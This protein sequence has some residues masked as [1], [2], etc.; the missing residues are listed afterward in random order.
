MI[1]PENT[2]EN[3]LAKEQI[4]HF[5]QQLATRK[6]LLLDEIRQ[7]LAD[8]E[9]ERQIDLIGGVGD[10]GDVA[11]AALLRGVT[12][13]EVI[14]DVQEVRDIVAAEQRIAAGRYGLCIDCEQA[15]RYKRLDAY[16]TAKRCYTCQVSHEKQRASTPYAAGRTW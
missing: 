7:V 13:A 9:S 8:S 14:R 16:P 6:T 4:T 10:S 5:S 1:K 11:T 12:E 2:P 15:I 3:V